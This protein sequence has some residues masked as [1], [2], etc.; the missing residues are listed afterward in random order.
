MK[1]FNVRKELLWMLAGAVL[2]ALTL[3]VPALGFFQWIT[4]MPIFLGVYHLCSDERVSGRRAYWY[5]FL[6]VFVYYFVIYH[7]FLRMHPLDFVGLDGAASAVVVACGWIG[8]SLLQAIVG[9]FMTLI[10]RRIDRTGAFLKCPMLRPFAFSALWVLFEWSSTLTWAGVP[11]GRLCLGQIDYLPILQSASLFGSYFVSFLILLVNGL[12]AYAL[13]RPIKRF[14]CWGIAAALFLSNLSFGLLVGVTEV[15]EENRVSVA[16]IQ[17]N[18]NSHDKWSLVSL[19][20]TKQAYESLTREAVARGAKLVVWSETV[21]PYD[22]NLRSDLKHYVSDL[23]KECNITL[24]V[25]SLYFDHDTEEEYNAV[26]LVEPDGSIREEIYAKRH[27]VPFGEYVPM[28]AL[29]EAL[30]PPLAEL[31]Q[32]DGVL[33]E[34]AD[35]AIFESEYGKLGTLICF[36]TIYEQLT[37]DSVRDGAELMMVC[38]NDSWFYDSVAV[39]Q[40]LAQSQLRAI[41]CG[42][43][44]VRSANT[45]VSAII[46]PDGEI[47]AEIDPLVSGYAAMDVAAVSQN[48]LYTVIGNL[49]VYLC[50]GFVAMLWT[51]GK[52]MRCLG[53]RKTGTR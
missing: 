17:G 26:Y 2:T 34:G 31:S 53:N 52:V 5:G 7:W 28:E 3:V 11:W 41:E 20:K 45:G 48:T 23:A 33:T 37:L 30:I 1:R 39:Y 4:M 14:L 42:R 49:F 27:L 24:A 15:N 22:F 19:Y 38:S 51:V 43:Y 44:V 8:L 40:H 29:I 18:I 35:T 9:G 12:L 50:L 25:G 6:T 10:M 32:I 47:M 36:D 13:L 16:V 21:F 46:A